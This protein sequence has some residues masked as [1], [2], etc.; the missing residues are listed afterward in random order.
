MNNISGV[1]RWVDSL[2]D[3]KANQLANLENRST[4]FGSKNESRLYLSYD[5]ESDY[6]FKEDDIENTD[7]YALIHDPLK[8]VRK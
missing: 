8:K 1:N 7:W 6:M 3:H 2:V 4:R 5:W